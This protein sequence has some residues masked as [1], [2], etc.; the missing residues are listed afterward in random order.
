MPGMERAVYRIIDANFNRGREALRVMED[1]CRFHLNSSPLSTQTKQL[2][3]QLCATIG[4]IDPQLL[5]ASRDTLGDIGTTIAVEN[6]LVRI[7]LMDCLTAAAKRASEALRT[8]SEVIQTFSPATAAS[9][10]KIRYA[11]YTLEKNISLAA[12]V[13]SKM[14]GV[15]FYVV[16]TSSIPAEIISLAGKC[17][18][19]G[20]DCIQLRAKDLADGQLLA[21]ATEFACICRSHGVLSVVNDRVDI[22]VGAGADG[23]HLGQNDVP[24]W[25]A[26]RLQIGPLIVG[27]STHNIEQLR[28]AIEEGADYVG[29]GP[30]F[31]TET[32]PGVKPAGLE[33]LR[34]A[35][36]IAAD[37]GFLGVAI[38]G[39]TPANLPEVLAAGATAVAVCGAVTNS[40]D[41][42]AACKG[43]AAQFLGKNP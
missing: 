16:I 13:R 26:R 18:R 33:Y 17:C 24:M 34:E 21:V 11:C 27:R 30:V 14:S 42:E 6:Q 10:E 38:G 32:K 9:I 28:A 19:G 8:L 2:R 4:T 40:P 37:A 20:A 31:P 3:H 43:F 15:R 5:L 22:A 25:V 36:P 12:A 29:I 7:D 41:P 23:V 39:I 1:V 35:A